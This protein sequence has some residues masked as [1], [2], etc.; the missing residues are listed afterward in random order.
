MCTQA[1]RYAGRGGREAG[2]RMHGDGG[3]AGWNTRRVT[4][5]G[6]SGRIGW[7]N[8]DMR[9]CGLD[10]GVVLLALGSRGVAQFD[11]ISDA[12]RRVSSEL[13]LAVW[14]RRPWYERYLDNAMRLTAA[15]Q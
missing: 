5:G 4:V 15:V 8:M 7:A 6:E 2:E 1:R 10:Y 9:S 14:S 12:Y 11:D 3:P 13:S